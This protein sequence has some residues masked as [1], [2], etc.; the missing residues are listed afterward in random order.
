M[1][2][3]EAQGVLVAELGQCNPFVPRYHLFRHERDAPL[4]K[5]HEELGATTF[6]VTLSD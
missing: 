4:V 5:V 6:D 2:T 1:H 3:Y